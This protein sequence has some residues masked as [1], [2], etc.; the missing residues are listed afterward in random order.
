MSKTPI[1]HQD[2]DCEKF[3]ETIPYFDAFK[4]I[5]K[6]SFLCFLGTVFYPVYTIVNAVI[7][8]HG[9]PLSLAGLGLGSLTTGLCSLSIGYNF[10]T[11]S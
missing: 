2:A 11:G 8:G 1:L 7:L 6:T 4:N 5:F 10:A 9:D 3:E